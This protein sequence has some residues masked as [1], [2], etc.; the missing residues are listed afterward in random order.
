MKGVV[1][2]ILLAVAIVEI[3]MVPGLAIDCAQVNFSLATCIP[4]LTGIEA[5]PSLACCAGVRSLK[6]LAPTPEDR[7]VACECAKAAAVRYPSLK[8]DAA[9]SLPKKC[10]VDINIPI[11]KTTNCQSIN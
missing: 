6:T 5:S 9:S 1:V 4:F 8:V 7:R 11:S 3:M 2:Q 10:G